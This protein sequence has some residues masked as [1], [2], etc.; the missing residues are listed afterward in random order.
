[1]VCVVLTNRVDVLDQLS[2]FVIWTSAS[3]KQKLDQL[4]LFYSAGYT[5]QYRVEI[6]AVSYALQ[7]DNEFDLLR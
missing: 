2:G 4:T 6:T 7:I 3:N 5:L 1:M